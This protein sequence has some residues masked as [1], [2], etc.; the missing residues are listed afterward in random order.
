VGA[1]DVDAGELLALA[2][3][4][5]EAAGTLLLDGAA[6]ARTAVGTKTS[7][8]DM[9]TEMDRASEALVVEGLLRARP[10]DGVLGEEGTARPGTSG[11]RWVVDPLDGTTNYLYGLPAW[12]VSVAAEVD[13]RVVAAVVADP[14]HGELYGATLGGGATC[15]GRRLDLGA[16]PPLAT[17]LVGTG[18][19]YEA[20]R[21]ARQAA[22]LTQ[23]LPR[24]RDVRR[25]GAAA[26][27]LCWVASGRLDAFY[28]KGLQ[29]W[30]LAAG[31]LVATEA[32]ALAGDLDGGLP[33]GTFAL[34][35]VPAVFGPLRDVLRSAGAVMA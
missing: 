35:A 16:G 30:D 28:E 7:P 3:S 32:G 22:V 14:S 26:L 19:S 29:P 34:A 6:R 24:V 31:A 27:D 1:P 20:D 11:V 33:S 25:A 5:A 2:R 18:F 21:R 8:T 10:D 13:G 12:A 4:V 9:V 17:A 23:V 15:N